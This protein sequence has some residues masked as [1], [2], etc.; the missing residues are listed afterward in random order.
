MKPNWANRTLWTGDNLGIMRGMASESVDL[1]YLDPPFNSNRNYGV[2]IEGSRV[3]QA[4]KDTWTLDK[5]DLA[6]L[7]SIANRAPALYRVVAAAG[8]S[9]SD[10]MQAYLTM[11][12]VR[13]LEMRRL[14]KETGSIYLHCDPTAS[15]YLKL[16]MD[17][18]FGRDHYRNEIIW[19]Y[20][21]SNSPIRNGYHSKHDVLL[22]YTKSDDFTFHR[23]YM[24]YSDSYLKE[25]YRYIDEDGRHYRKHSKRKDGSERHLYLDEAKGVPVL[26]W[27]TDIIGFGTATQSAERT[28]YPTQK[29]LE[30]LRRVIR[31]SSDE[32]DVVLDPFCGCATACVAAEELGRQW[33]GI[34]LSPLAKELIKERFGTNLG[35]FIE[36]LQNTHFRDDIPPPFLP[37]DDETAR[38]TSAHPKCY[39]KWKNKEYLFGKQRGICLTCGGEYAYKNLEVDHVVPRAEGG[40]DTLDNL[41]LLCVRCNR[42]KGSMSMKDFKQLMLKELQIGKHKT[43]QY[44]QRLS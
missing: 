27:W 26:S 34:D 28:G 43:E 15:H 13:L 22:F 42:R 29:P 35:L 20:K 24:P 40:S 9:H 2:P 4:F 7:G 32:G 44:L 1:I 11:M 23:Q 25:T 5:D 8:E 16:L 21:A 19:C 3:E 41:Q 36:A 37:D 10:G 6:W 17:S 14:L 31:A 39:K 12:A 18:V 38:S 33:V 30:L